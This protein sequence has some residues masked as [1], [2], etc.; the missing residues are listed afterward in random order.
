[1]FID[2][3]VPDTATDS[4]MPG[5]LKTAIENVRRFENRPVRGSL[6]PP[7]YLFVTNHPFEY[8]LT[9]TSFR[10]FVLGEGF[11]IPEFKSDTPFPS[12]GAAYRARQ[13]HAD[14]H[15]L[16]ESMREHTQVPSTFDGDIP[17]L[18]FHENPPRMLIGERYL[19][20]YGHGNE[21]P[22]TLTT[23]TVSIEEGVAYGGYWLDSGQSVIV[24]CPLT[25]DELA[26]YKRHPDT[27]F[28][29][30][31]QA[32]RTVKTPMELFDFFH[33]SCRQMS[34]EKLLDVLRGAPDYEA[35]CRLPQEELA[36]T[37]A[38]RCTGAA[39]QQGEKQTPES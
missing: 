25:E 14:M 24:T 33:E 36:I 39:I 16:L 10:T 30:P 17:E 2:V 21:V 31:L 35:L 27:F 8:N 23:A 5:F 4:E 32:G 37:Y 1:V 19:I 7:A 11:R 22:T 18:A 3:N 6:R 26:A 20:P 34:R 29:I 9:G 12:A 15:Q 28:G 38:E 13:R